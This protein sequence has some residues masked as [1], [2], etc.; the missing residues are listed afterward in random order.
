M[1]KCLWHTALPGHVTVCLRLAFFSCR[2]LYGYEEKQSNSPSA[3]I[4]SVRAHVEPS[5]SRGHVWSG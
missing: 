3:S 2:P 1:Q 4:N 5:D